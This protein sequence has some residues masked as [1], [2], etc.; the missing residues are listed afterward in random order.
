MDLTM[1]EQEA[2]REMLAKIRQVAEDFVHEYFGR[3][4][5]LVPKERLLYLDSVADNGKAMLWGLAATIELHEHPGEHSAALAVVMSSVEQIGA[6]NKQFE[7][8]V[9]CFRWAATRCLGDEFTP[10]MQSGHRKLAA[11]TGTHWQAAATRDSN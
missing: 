6:L 8:T 9:E 5:M 1:E 3:L 4:A 7:I 10:A 11:L 2:V